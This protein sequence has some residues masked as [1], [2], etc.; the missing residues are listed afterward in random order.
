MPRAVT[1]GHDG[2][3]VRIIDQRALPQALRYLELRTLDEVV[4][5]IRTLAVRGAPAIGVAGAMGLAAVATSHVALTPREF[6]VALDDAARRIAAARPTAV[7]LPWAIARLRRRAATEG[8]LEPVHLAAVLLDEAERLRAEDEAMC[9]RIGT[10]GARLLNDG[11]RVMTHCNA[12]ALATAGIGTALAPVYAARDAGR[13]VEVLAT[14]TR[15]LWQGARLTMWELSQA[16][17]P[18]TLIADGAAASLLRGGAADCVLVGADRIAANGDVANK[19]G[20]YPI[21]LAAHAHHVPF[22]VAAPA[23]TIDPATPTGADIDIEERDADELMSVAGA[24]HVVVG[25][26]GRNPAFDV[27]PASLV[28]AIVTDAGIVLP[29]YDFSA[30]APPR[31]APPHTPPA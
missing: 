7:N 4:D 26:R 2:T 15:P 11:A 16:G 10:Y 29:P 8:H 3:S 19:I 14:E 20:T 23:S 18:C 12:G 5:A 13:H 31:T 21:A 25:A 27:T 24:R 1:W 6:A 28:T 17:V 30:S 9:A 22:Y